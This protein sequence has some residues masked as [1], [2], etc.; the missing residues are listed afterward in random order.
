MRPLCKRLPTSRQIQS[1]NDR[2]LAYRIW[3]KRWQTLLSNVLLLVVRRSVLTMTTVSLATDRH[4][5][6]IEMACQDRLVRSCSLQLRVTR[7]AL[8]GPPPPGSQAWSHFRPDRAHPAR[9]S[10][11]AAFNEAACKNTGLVSMLLLLLLPI[12]IYATASPYRR[13]RR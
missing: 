3:R 5:R 12:C 11:R 9:S 4:L 6:S 10:R 13:F 7:L 1:A 2:S 8:S